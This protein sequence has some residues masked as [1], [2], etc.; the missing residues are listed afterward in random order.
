MKTLGRYGKIL[1]VCLGVLLPAAACQP[2]DPSFFRRNAAGTWMAGESLFLTFDRNGG[3]L[4]EGAAPAPDGGRL[5]GSGK[6][7]QRIYCCSMEM[8]GVAPGLSAMPGT[9]RIYREYEIVSAD[10]STMT[11]RP[12]RFEVDGTEVF[13]EQETEVWR[14]LTEKASYADSLQGA[15]HCER[16]AGQDRTDIRLTFKKDGGYDFYT[17]DSGTSAWVL[18]E[19]N[20]GAYRVLGRELKLSQFANPL[21]GGT[22]AVSSLFEAALVRVSPKSG[23]MHWQDRDGRQWFFRSWEEEQ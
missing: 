1:A 15:W 16:A 18:D 12:L 3:V 11:L 2:E 14:R 8:Y 13:P 22:E 19:D 4:A 23:E 17:Y 7:S 21:F 10:D 6:L 20:A 9:D 5:W